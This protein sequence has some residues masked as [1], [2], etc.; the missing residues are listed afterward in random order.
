MADETTELK[1]ENQKLRAENDR[2]K[3]QLTEAS[4][5]GVKDNFSIV[6]QV[7]ALASTSLKLRDQL[8]EVQRELD[9]RN[10]DNRRLQ[11]LLKDATTAATD[12]K[13]LN[14]ESK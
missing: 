7:S 2:L 9:T 12:A 10:E 6:Q 5:G 1:L 13:S 14:K 3:K 8:L 4:L 11:K